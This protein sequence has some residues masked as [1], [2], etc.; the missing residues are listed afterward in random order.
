[1]FTL[2]RHTYDENKQ[3]IA[4]Y[5]TFPHRQIIPRGVS[6]RSGE[7]LWDDC[8]YAKSNANTFVRACAYRVFLTSCVG[9]N[10]GMSPR[11]IPPHS[12]WKP[13]M[14]SPPSSIVTMPNFAPFDEF[15]CTPTLRSCERANFIA[16]NATVRFTI[17]PD[18]APERASISRAPTFRTC[19]S[20][21][22]WISRKREKGYSI[23]LTHTVDA[24]VFST[25]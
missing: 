3:N 16:E 23:A 18:Y 5:S 19:Y 24:D 17:V 7:S 9:I 11:L 14:N 13:F 15:S 1:M 4:I 10:L 21:A 22:T 20:N 6:Y 12:V 25:F 8:P 2:L